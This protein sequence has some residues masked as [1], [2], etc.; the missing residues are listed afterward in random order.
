[1]SRFKVVNLIDKIFVALCVFLICFA[2]INFYIK[3]LTATFWLSVLIAFC[4][5]FLL[6]YFSNKKQSKITKLK[7]KNEDIEKTFLAFRLLDANK[8]FEILNKCFDVD[9]IFDG[10]YK[11]KNHIYFS[12]LNVD[13]LDEANFLN[14]IASAKK[15]DFDSLTIICK[16]A[17]KSLKLDILKGKKI[18]IINKEKL[19]EKFVLANVKID[20]SD[21]NLEQKKFSWKD[22]AVNF[23]NASKSKSYFTCGLVLLFSS[24]VLPYNFYYIIFGS[25]LV[26]FALICKLLPM[27]NNK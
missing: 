3:S 18:E 7:L 19:F 27:F 10:F 17:D 11:A 21:L 14:I 22:F 15:Y 1:M 2:W 12:A 16:N 24:I 9:K 6:F 4:I 25:M 8:Q 20:Y 13:V 26:L 23:F 5:C